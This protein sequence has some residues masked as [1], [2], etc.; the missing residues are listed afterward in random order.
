MRKEPN[1]IQDLLV[2]M[3]NKPLYPHIDERYELMFYIPEEHQLYVLLENGKE[4]LYKLTLNDVFKI[5]NKG[6]LNESCLVE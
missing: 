3:G 4:L 1:I 5:I 6:E 2:I